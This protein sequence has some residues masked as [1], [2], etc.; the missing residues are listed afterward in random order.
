MHHDVGL[1]VLDAGVVS[2]ETNAK[3]EGRGDVNRDQ[4]VIIESAKRH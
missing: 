2:D 1:K 4:I 3:K